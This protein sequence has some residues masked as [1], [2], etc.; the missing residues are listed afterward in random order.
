MN[1]IFTSTLESNNT[2]NVRQLVVLRN[3]A[4]DLRFL[5]IGASGVGFD[6]EIYPMVVGRFVQVDLA[7]RANSPRAR[8]S[9]SLP[10]ML[11]L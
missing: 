9:S 7:A 8:L 11:K 10:L 3:P 2:N 4:T 6:F 5:A 1:D